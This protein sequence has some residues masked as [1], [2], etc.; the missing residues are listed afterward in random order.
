MPPHAPTNGSHVFQLLKHSPDRTTDRFLLPVL[1]LTGFVVSVIGTLG[2][3][4]IP[5]IAHERGVS[6]ETA[7]WLLTITL[8]VGA[9]ASPVFGRLADGPRRRQVILG[10]LL[11][12]VLGSLLAAVARTFPLL[13]FGRGL[14]G[15]GQS[16]VPLAIAVARDRLPRDRMRSGIAILSVTT[17]AGAGLGY[18]ITGFI[19]EHYSYQAGF[20]VA[21]GVSLIA[22][23]FVWYVVPGNPEA[24]RHPLDIT[25][26]ILLSV[27]LSS[28]LLAIS[29][30]KTWG[31][32]SAIVIG[33]LI[34]S[35]VLTVVW[36]L[37]ELRVTHPLIELRL[38][39]RRMVLAADLAAIL[40]GTALYAMSSLVNRYLQTPET[41]GYGFDSSLVVVGLVLMPLSVGSIVSSRISMPLT[42]RFGPGRVVAGGSVLVALDMTYLAFSRSHLWEFA[43]AIL[44]LGLGIGLT[45]AMMPA[46]I[47]RSVPPEETGSAT[48]LN[49]VLR[50]IGGSI[51]SAASIAILSS[52][53]QDNGIYPRDEGYTVA[54]L[55]GAA[56]CLAAAICCMVLIRDVKGEE[57]PTV[58][59]HTVHSG[60]P[61]G[62]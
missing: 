13:L 62:A 47:V 11:L 26:A 41:A 35:V 3:L 46:L 42:Q 8:L 44:I 34:T 54:F 29:Q 50:L 32:S 5:T 36:I 28:L 58:V 14:Q 10:T 49:Q 7:Q 21:M 48:G 6:L 38:M 27:A 15:L 12:V 56:I 33:L 55:A 25:G 31:W 23:A 30:G 53:T 2:A 19:A 40:M 59:A 16:L 45:F 9:V 39:M 18:P 4:M 60:T 22:L 61:P 37:H 24:E 57:T 17:A 52:M 51:G 43:L 1:V 20:W